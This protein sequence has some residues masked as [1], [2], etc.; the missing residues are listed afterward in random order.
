M[1]GISSRFITD[2]KHGELGFFLREAQSN[3]CIS[4]EI[5]GNYINLY[6]K[7]GNAV[8]ITEMN[9]GYSFQFDSKYCLNKGNDQNFQYLNNLGKRDT[10]QFIA[11]FPTLLSEMDSWFDVHPKPE[12]DFQHNL[13]KHNQKNP[14]VLDIE[15]AGRKSDLRSFRLDMLAVNQTSDG[16]QLII[17]ENKFGTGAI[18]G[19]AGP[20]KALR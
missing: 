12:R 5:R 14:I 18:G 17:I 10:K 7:G 8:K 11:A 6:Y 9:R 2:L 16:Y 19:S 15:Y 20:E 1:R 13:I 3:P 4:L